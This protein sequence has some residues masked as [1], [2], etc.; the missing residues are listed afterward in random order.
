MRR[1][2]I[3]AILS[4]SVAGA[5]WA[6]PKVAV[7]DALVPNNIDQSVLIPVTE[8]IIERLVISG[9]FTVLDR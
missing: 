8:K 7:L 2:I 4:F 1:F 9:R 3:A 6:Q 5:L